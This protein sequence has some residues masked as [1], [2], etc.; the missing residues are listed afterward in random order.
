MSTLLGL[1]TILAGSETLAM[2]ALTQYAKS[3]NL[4][5]MAVGALIYGLVIPFTI[6][7]SVTFAG[8]GT[9]NFMWN[10]ITTVSMIVIG[11]FWF[12]DKISHLHI[13]SLLLG[14]GSL[15]VLYL[16]EL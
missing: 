10:I 6:T 12:G 13:I 11:H 9:V 14:I 7:Q 8:I 2:S 4:V 15:T 3:Q 1:T 16:A 5:Y